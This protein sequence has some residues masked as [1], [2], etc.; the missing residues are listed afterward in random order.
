MLFLEI[1]ACTFFLLNQF[2]C[3]LS[4][5][6][7]EPANWRFKT[8]CTVPSQPTKKVVPYGMARNRRLTWR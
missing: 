5:I 8:R 4:A 6:D 7:D 3:L 1:F 2:H